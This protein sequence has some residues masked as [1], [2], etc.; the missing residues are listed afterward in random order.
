M[1]FVGNF[2]QSGMTSHELTGPQNE[3]SHAE[4]AG[5]SKP[6]ALLKKNWIPIEKIKRNEKIAGIYVIGLKLLGYVIYLYLGRSNDVKGRLKGHSRKSEQKIHEF[7]QFKG[8]N[9]S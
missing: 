6:A 8:K 9:S 3:S 1:K 2:S 4:T 7:I 5:I